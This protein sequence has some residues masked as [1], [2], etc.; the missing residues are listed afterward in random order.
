MEPP[1]ARQLNHVVPD[2]AAAGIA[3]RVT[4]HTLRYSFGAHADL[5]G[6]GEHD[7]ISRRAAG[8]PGIVVQ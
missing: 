8:T 5:G 1:S 7:P 6:L 3:K 2:A 4:M